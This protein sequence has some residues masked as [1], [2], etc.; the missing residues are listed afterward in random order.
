MKKQVLKFQQKH[1][2]VVRSLAARNSNGPSLKE[3]KNDFGLYNQCHQYREWHYPLPRPFCVTGGCSR[4]STRPLNADL[5]ISLNGALAKVTCHPGHVV[6]GTDQVSLR[7]SLPL[8]KIL[9]RLGQR[10]K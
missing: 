3:N 9:E 2:I 8:L 1:F 5:E 10:Y 7:Y 4:I 6:S